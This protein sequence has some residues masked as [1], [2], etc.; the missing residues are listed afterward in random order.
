MSD[1]LHWFFLIPRIDSEEK[2]FNIIKIVV[3]SYIDKDKN[4][5][6]INEFKEVLI[7]YV[8]ICPIHIFIF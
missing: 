4:K 8:L 6:L 1:T 2:N 5:T 7:R 3:W